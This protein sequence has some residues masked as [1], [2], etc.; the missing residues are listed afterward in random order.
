VSGDNPF[1]IATKLGV[2]SNLQAQWVNE[3]VTLN[4][5]NPSTMFVG[6]VL[7]LPASTPGQIAATP[8]P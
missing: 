6:Q 5:I 4:G 8:S 3:L 1:V 7:Q 2:P